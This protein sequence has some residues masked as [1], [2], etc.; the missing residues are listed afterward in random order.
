MSK[1]TYYKKKVKGIELTVA[2]NLITLGGFTI[3]EKDQ[4]VTVVNLYMEK[5]YDSIG[6]Y[7]D[8]CT[9][10]EIKGHERIDWKLSAFTDSKC[11][12]DNDFLYWV[13][14]LKYKFHHGGWYLGGQSVSQIRTFQKLYEKYI[15]EQ[16]HKKWDTF[17][18]GFGQNNERTS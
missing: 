6:L 3:L 1:W 7:H 4:K 10:V 12:T 18:R 15:D 5:G 9:G 14:E 2:H 8:R 11:L 13:D 17:I 16:E